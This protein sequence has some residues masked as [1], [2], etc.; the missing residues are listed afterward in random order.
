MSVR[1]AILFWQRLSGGLSHEW[2]SRDHRRDN[3]RYLRVGAPLSA[4]NWHRV[5][6]LHIGPVW[7]RRQFERRWQ[8]RASGIHAR[9][10]WPAGPL[11]YAAGE[12]LL[13]RLATCSARGGWR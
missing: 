5:R 2:N 11:A 13:G 10:A 12:R 1:L 8:R 3:R 4:W 6:A 9:Q 7:S